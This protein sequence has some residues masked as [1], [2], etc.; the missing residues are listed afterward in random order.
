MSTRTLVSPLTL[1]RRRGKT[2]YWSVFSGVVLLFALAF[3]FPVYWMVTG[4]MKSPD[5]VTRTPPTL[6]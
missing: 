3:L 5:E 2:L 4:A 6:V 1:A